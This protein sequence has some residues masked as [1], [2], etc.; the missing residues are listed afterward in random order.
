MHSSATFLDDD[1]QVMLTCLLQIWYYQRDIPG[2]DRV[3]WFFAVSSNSLAPSLSRVIYFLCDTAMSGLQESLAG[4]TTEKSEMIQREWQ[5][6]R[7]ILVL[8]VDYY[9][10]RHAGYRIYIGFTVINF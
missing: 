9:Y 5:V 8:K 7:A 4:Y 2:W 10:N 1:A 3:Q 6:M